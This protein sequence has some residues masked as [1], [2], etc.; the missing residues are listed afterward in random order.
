MDK[1]TIKIEQLI[2]K[3]QSQ[4]ETLKEYLQALISNLVTGKVKIDES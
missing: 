4:I 1:E 2:L 3:I